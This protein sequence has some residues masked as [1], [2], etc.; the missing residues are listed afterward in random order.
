MIKSGSAIAAGV[1]G[2][3]TPFGGF[4]FPPIPIL[5]AVFGHMGLK[6][7]Q[8]GYR[9]GSGMALTGIWFGWTFIVL[10]FLG[11]LGFL[12]ATISGLAGS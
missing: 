11:F 4:L 5:A 7:V 12:Y 9:E 3:V 10:Y 1:L 8:A 2:I 6:E